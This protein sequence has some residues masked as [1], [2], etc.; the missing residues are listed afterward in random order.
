[1]ISSSIH[2]QEKKLKW[3]LKVKQD[4]KIFENMNKV[5]KFPGTQVKKE[6]ENN[7]ENVKGT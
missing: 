1:M 2:F 4:M 3:N 5:D 7:L 6:R